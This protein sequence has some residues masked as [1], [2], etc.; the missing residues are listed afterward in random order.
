M[1]RGWLAGVAA[2]LLCSLAGPLRAE[3]IEV[4]VELC[5]AADGSGS[6]AEDEFR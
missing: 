5:L 1:A 2:T 3:G 6:I 4:D